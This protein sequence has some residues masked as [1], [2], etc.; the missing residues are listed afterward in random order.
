MIPAKSGT[1]PKNR[2]IGNRNDQSPV[3]IASLN[4]GKSFKMLVGKH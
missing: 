2:N 3:E 1:I 4:T